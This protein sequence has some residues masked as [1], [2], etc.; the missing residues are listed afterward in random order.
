[1]SSEQELLFG[2]YQRIVLKSG[3][4]YPVL[5]AQSSEQEL[6]AAIDRVILVNIDSIGGSST[7][8]TFGITVD[9]AGTVLTVGSK[10]FVTVPYDCTLTNWYLAADQAGDVVFDLKRGGTSIVGTGNA[11]TLSSAQTANAAVSGWDSVAITAGDIIE[12]EI[13]GTPATITRVNLVIKAS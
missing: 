6:L 12:F 1:M 13:T 11:P 2:I 4:S 7:P 3:K 5:T 10:G 8:P 9:G